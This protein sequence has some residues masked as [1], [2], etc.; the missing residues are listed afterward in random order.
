MNIEINT[1][2][3][4]KSLKLRTEYASISEI[5]QKVRKSL[6]NYVVDNG[7]P[8]NIYLDSVE[9]LDIENISE[10]SIKE[11][12][13]GLISKKIL[14]MNEEGNINFLYPVSTLPTDH[15]VTLA[16]GR[17]F[18]SMCGIDA[19]GATM[20]FNQDVHIESKCSQCGEKIVIDIKDGNTDY[21]SSKEI[22][23][24]H[25]DTSKNEEWAGNC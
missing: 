23:V 6:I 8:F 21:L 2:R 13:E 1:I 7:I 3:G 10:I 11:S 15:Q 18:Y 22:Y 4:I 25:M 14:R 17:R 24:I 5:E 12:I 19:L 9:L 16:D 20:T